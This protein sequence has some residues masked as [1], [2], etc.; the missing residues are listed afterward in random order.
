MHGIHRT[1]RQAQRARRIKAHHHIHESHTASRR[2]AVREEVTRKVL[3]GSPA[4]ASSSH[5]PGRARPRSSSSAQHP[6]RCVVPGHDPGGEGTTPDMK[7]RSAR[8][9]RHHLPRCHDQHFRSRTASHTSPSTRTRTF[10]TS[11]RGFLSFA[12]GAST[13]MADMIVDKRER[14]WE[15]QGGTRLE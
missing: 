7:T 3:V 10:L 9:V 8:R 15:E 14:C 11:K 1:G 6:P 13:S 4:R 2:D 5:H 12:T